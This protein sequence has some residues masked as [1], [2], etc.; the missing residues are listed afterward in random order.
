MNVI[1]LINNMHYKAERLALAFALTLLAGLFVLYVYLLSMSVIHVV[2]SKEA[3]ENLRDLRSEIAY[4]E[5]QYMEMQNSI[6][7]EIVE[8]RGYIAVK[9]KIFIARDNTSLVTKR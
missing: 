1:A 6:S 8:Q 2:I 7:E 3:E 9:D 4:L 5:S